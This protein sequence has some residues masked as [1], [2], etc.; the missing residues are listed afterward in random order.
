MSTTPAPHS[1]PPLLVKE[2][3]LQSATGAAVTAEALQFARFAAN[4]SPEE[5]QWLWHWWNRNS[6]QASPHPLAHA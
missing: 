4:A 6:L 3:L 2:H 1:H 5:R